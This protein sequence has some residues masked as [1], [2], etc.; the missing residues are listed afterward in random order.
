[1]SEEGEK[2]YL[3]LTLK[4]VVTVQN[5][6]S[7]VLPTWGRNYR[8]VSLKPNSEGISVVP[9]PGRYYRAPG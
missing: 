2:G 9:I 8:G 4:L 1:M 5:W 7:S 3:Y 6:D